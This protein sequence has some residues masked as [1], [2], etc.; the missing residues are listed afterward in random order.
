MKFYVSHFL[1]FFLKIAKACKTGV[2]LIFF[3]QLPIKQI[4]IN[5]LILDKTSSKCMWK[6]K[7][8]LVLS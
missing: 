3:G 6:S 4:L 5:F 2:N 7:M 8:Y 1:N